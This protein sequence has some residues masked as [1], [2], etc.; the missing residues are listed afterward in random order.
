MS[1]PPQHSPSPA[2]RPDLDELGAPATQI[3]RDRDAYLGQSRDVGRRLTDDQVELF[4]ADEP[5]AALQRELERLAPTY[6][7]LHDVGTSSSLRLLQA[8]A[9]TTGKVMRLTVRRQ[10]QGVALATLQF[11]EI[12]GSDGSV[13]RVYSTDVDADSHAR[14]QIARVLV[15]HARLAVLVFGELPPHALAAALQPMLD[16]AHQDRWLNRQMLMIPLGSPAPV[17]GFANSFSATGLHVQVTPRVARPADAWSFIGSTWNQLDGV[18]AP[19]S[20]AAQRPAAAPDD[21]EPTQPMGLR[22]APGGIN[23]F[24]YVQRCASVKGMISCC[25]FDRSDG[26]PLAHA[27]GQPSA[28]RMQALG[29]QL[30]ATASDIGTQMGTRAEVLEASISFPTHHVLLRTLPGQPGVVLHAVLDAT[31][32]NLTLARAQ[33]QRLDP[34]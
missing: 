16:A 5:A 28:E 34:G 17:G 19:P 11:V 25:V 9:A 4:V 21:E 32:G 31:S 27:G 15:S 10:G 22:R 2:R 18:A 23:W 14:Q 8:M 6:I 29:E 1:H 20:A 33:L 26:K 12:G 13:L 24:D 7:A 3:V 30:L